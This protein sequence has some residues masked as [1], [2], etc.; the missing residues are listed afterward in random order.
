MNVQE[1][2]KLPFDIH[3]IF[4]IRSDEEFL[5]L[6]KKSFAFQYEHNRIYRNYVDLSG[7]K[8]SNIT[9]LDDIPFLPISFF[10]THEVSCASIPDPLIFESSG[11]T[12]QKRSKHFVIDPTIYQLSFIK[13]FEHFYGHP[14]DY[15][16]LALL[17]SYM[18]NDQSSLIY[19]IDQLTELT[20]D[21]DSGFF[22][23]D[24]DRLLEVIERKRQH[25][26]VMLIGVS[27]AL[28]DFAEKYGPDLSDCI[29]M[30]TGGMKGRRREL[31]KEELHQELCAGF[32]VEAIHSEYGMTELLSQAYSFGSGIFQAPSWMRIL[33]RQYNDPYCYVENKSGGINV[34]DL[35]NIYSCS[36]IATQD[37]GRIK[38]DGFE[39]LGRFDDSDLRGCN[40]LVQ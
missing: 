7:K 12:D 28:L 17:P 16:I 20:A 30:E 22:L 21:S 40:L 36:F 32:N 11:T 29:V 6:A 24:Y 18:D 2:Q 37:L 39:I 31:T 5:E 15:V 35:A 34:I 1:V 19:M 25:K 23:N 8:P 27:Y 13:A 3:E 9:A 10:K 4:K 33:T 14:E 26:K 38:N